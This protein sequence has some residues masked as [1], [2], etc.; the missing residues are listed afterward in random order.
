MARKTIDMLVDAISKDLIPG[1]LAVACDYFGGMTPET[2][3]YMAVYGLYT[4]MIKILE[5]DPSMIELASK[6]GKLNELIHHCHKIRQ[7]NYYKRFV[8]SGTNLAEMHYVPY[9]DDLSEC[10]DYQSYIKK[11][12]KFEQ[13][14]SNMKLNKLGTF[15]MS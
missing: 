13:R 2:P 1:H 14:L 11:C 5:V 4:G 9:E 3:E 7:S 6:C 8:Q 15:G 12:K 10:E